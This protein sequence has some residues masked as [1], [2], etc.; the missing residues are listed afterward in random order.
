MATLS[1]E[2][3]WSKSQDG[4]F[5]ECRRRYYYH[6]YG[7]WEGWP[8]GSG[9]ARAQELYIL[10]QLKS[11]RMWAGEAVHETIAQVLKGIRA[12]KPLSE[13][14]ARQRLSSGM[15]KQFAESA[16]R[17]YR[18]H[19]KKSCGLL[20]HEYQLKVPDK[21]WAQLH[22]T[23]QRCL[24]NFYQTKAYGTL[25]G[26]KPA[27][28]KAIEQLAQ[29]SVDGVLVYAKLDAAVA[30]GDGLLII[31]WKTGKEDSMEFELQMGVYLLFALRKWKCAPERVRIVQAELAVP[32]EVSHAGLPAKI[33]WTEHYIRNS[34]GAIKRLLPESGKSPAD[35]SGFLQVNSYKKCS[36]CNYQ[37]VCRPS[38]LMEDRDDGKL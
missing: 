23:A 34:I 21:S 7:A 16:S 30:T 36:W 17:R 22:E 35:E 24:R 14:E 33:E 12:G 26:V 28:W 10:K 32:K 9:N 6:R 18:S 8:G 1:N 15:R 2:F 4:L 3:S 11:G 37:R 27:Q 20:E 25:A 5:R 29:F 19:P 38:V 13:E 31:D